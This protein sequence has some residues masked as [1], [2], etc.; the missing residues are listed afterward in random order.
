MTGTTTNMDHDDEADIK[1]LYLDHNER[2]INAYNNV[3][4]FAGP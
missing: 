1:T 4:M 3:E 2:C